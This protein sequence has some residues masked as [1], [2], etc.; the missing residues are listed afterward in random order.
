MDISLELARA[1]EDGYQEGKKDAVRHGKWI[2]VLE[3]G[4]NIQCRCSSCFSKDVRPKDIVVPYC[5]HCGAR[6]DGK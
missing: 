5:W 4:D 2:N 6:M 1:F 3:L